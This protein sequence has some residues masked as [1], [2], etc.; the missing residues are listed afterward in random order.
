M[1][2]M[3]WFDTQGW[4]RSSILLGA[5]FVFCALAPA[6]LR[7]KAQKGL[8]FLW[9]A[10]VATLIPLGWYEWRVT[11][12]NESPDLPLFHIAFYA[13]PVSVAATVAT[14]A[15]RLF[16]RRQSPKFQFGVALLATSVLLPLILNGTMPAFFV[17]YAL[18]DRFM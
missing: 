4:Y 3:H 16:A 8:A 11:I 6:A 13:L 2:W 17:I 10:V 5:P 12:A 1:R 18:A 7:W 15:V 14:A 9:L